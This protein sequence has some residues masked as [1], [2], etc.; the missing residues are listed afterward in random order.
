[1]WQATEALRLYPSHSPELGKNEQKQRAKTTPGARRE[2]A[3]HK[4]ERATR[5]AR[6]PPEV[7]TLGGPA[8]KASRPHKV[9]TEAYCPP[10]GTTSKN[11]KLGR[12]ESSS[13]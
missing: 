6:R 3:G 5:E 12:V 9:E 2:Q 8:V 1:M 10:L 13:K 11:R 7:R 4:G